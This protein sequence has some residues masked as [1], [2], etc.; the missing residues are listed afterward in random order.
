[1]TEDEMI[2]FAVESCLIPTQHHKGFYRQAILDFGNAVK[3]NELKRCADLVEQ[4]GMSGYGTLA[5]S[6][7]IREEM[8][9]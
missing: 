8:K 9:K 3:K 5:I 7:A 4:M 1:M 2:G 6:V